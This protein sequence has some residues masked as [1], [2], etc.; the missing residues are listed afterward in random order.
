MPIL[1]DGAPAR[2]RYP[3]QRGI[4]ARLGCCVCGLVFL[5]AATPDA[6]AD[7]PAFT[8]LDRP[9]YKL[10]TICSK[11][12]DLDAEDIRRLAENFELMH[13]KLTPEQFDAL[14]AINP[15][16]KGLTYVNSTYTRSAEDAPL[17]EAKYR[18]SL[19]MHL[20]AELCEPIDPDQTR[21]L[22]RSPS[23]RRGGKERRR[24]IAIRASTIEGNL[25]PVDRPSTRFYV[26]WIRIGDEL[27][28]VNRFD[29]DTGKLEVERGFDNSRPVAHPMGAR[30]FSPVYLGFKR[31]HKDK[32]PGLH[33]GGPGDRVRYVLD[34]GSPAGYPFLARTALAAMRENRT[35][36]V[37]L[38]TLNVGDFNLSDCLGR[39]VTPWD[40]VH[41]QPYA[42]DHFRLGQ[43]KKMAFLQEYVKQETGKYPFLVANNLKPQTYYPGHGGM[44]RLLESTEVK[45]RPL[46]GFCMEG[47]LAWY[48]EDHWRPRIQMLMHAARNGLAA[49][50]IHGPAGGKSK[51][52]ERDTP[53][54]E[55][56]ERFGYASYLLA[57]ESDGRTM[58]GT[59]AFYRNGDDR[60]VRL[61][62]MY[63][64]PI[65]DPAET[66][67]P[68]QLDRYLVP[69]TKVFRRRFTGGVVLV[70]TG[71]SAQ[72]IV[73]EARMLDPD[74]GK[75]IS[76]VVLPS[77]SGKIL[78]K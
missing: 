26:F 48:G 5:L 32:Y 58:M 15:N 62:P 49:M 37:W 30:V 14:R 25:S 53:E 63:F 76:S 38:D 73:L 64:Y 65:G 34:P 43:E 7:E 71:T 61:H 67:P 69:G 10:Y 51:L 40:F 28:R 77:I 55:R 70:N 2:T 22:V 3:D 72:R 74:R 46:D 41:D 60:E 24:P 17:V 54:R 16:F 57:V 50:P 13:G 75:T 1:N 56:A 42:A 39:P 8:P 68:D 36:G 11:R 66:V 27:M 4:P 31:T 45:P 29:P 12:A 52:A 59:Y 19:C 21:F 6:L 47:G 35:D 18:R 44:Q 20:S 78:L 9:A 33:P 23:A